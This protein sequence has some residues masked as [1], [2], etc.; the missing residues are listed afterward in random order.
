MKKPGDKNSD[1]LESKQ[2]R[3]NGRPADFFPESV[4]QLVRLLTP[5]GLMNVMNLGRSDFFGGEFRD[6]LRPEPRRN[7]ATLGCI[8]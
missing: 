2:F 1:Y 6:I 7:G 4:Q 8:N 3:R 5:T